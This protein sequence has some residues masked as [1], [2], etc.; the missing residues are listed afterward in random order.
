ME[1]SD[2]AEIV[3][4]YGD[5]RRSQDLAFERGEL[6]GAR[7]ARA[8]LISILV[9]IKDNPGAND[10]DRNAVARVLE[11]IHA[12]E[13]ES[14]SP[15]AIAKLAS[16]LGRAEGE[17]KAVRNIRRKLQSLK[18]A[19]VDRLGNWHWVDPLGRSTGRAIELEV[20]NEEKESRPI[21]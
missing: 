11:I 8:D 5:V 7:R 3:T 21:G 9:A 4:T 14:F 20:A 6:S 19:N 1:P 18:V 10:R 16:E 13:D 15:A 12:V 17:A 2:F